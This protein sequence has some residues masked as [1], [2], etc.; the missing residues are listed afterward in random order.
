M[1]LQRGCRQEDKTNIPHVSQGDAPEVLGNKASGWQSVKQQISALC[2]SNNLNS[3]KHLMS[4]GDT[5]HSASPRATSPVPLSRF[6]ALQSLL[7]HIE[8]LSL[9]LCLDY[10]A[11]ALFNYFMQA[12]LYF[13]FFAGITTLNHSRFSSQSVSY[14]DIKASRPRQLCHPVCV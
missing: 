1:H 4:P 7:C 3:P 13:F 14:R 8:A 11:E 9:Y 6:W 10:R 2:A 5:I 12:S